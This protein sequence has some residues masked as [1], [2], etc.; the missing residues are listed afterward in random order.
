MAA[1]RKTGGRTKGVPNKATAGLK[2]AFQKHGNGLV[3]ALLA[4]TKSDN[5]RVRLGAIQACLDRGWGKPAQTVEAN[6]QG[7]ITIK[8]AK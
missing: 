7:D 2:A 5:E 1:G 6:L 8:W 3:D 4:L